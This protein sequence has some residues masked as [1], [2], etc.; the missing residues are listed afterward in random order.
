MQRMREIDQ[1][2]TQTLQQIRAF[3]ASIDM[4]SICLLSDEAEIAK[5]AYPGIYRIDIQTDGSASDL[6]A[7][8]NG[9]RAEWEHPDFQGWKTP[10]LIKK[11]IAAHQSLAPWMP[12]YVGKSKNVARRVL[13]HIN[14][15][16]E[17]TTF[18]LKLKARSKTGQRRLRFHALEVPVKNYAAVVP[19]LEASL[20]DRF[21]PIIGRQ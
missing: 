15:S 7:W 13:E 16:A 14:L 18:A 3:A 19:V 5:H 11:R 8:I 1:Q 6:E 10:R 17:K 2:L 21:N 20:R 12:L 4:P 9:F